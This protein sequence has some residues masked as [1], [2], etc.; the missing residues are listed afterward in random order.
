MLLDVVLRCYDG[1]NVHTYAPRITG[2]QTPKAEV[3]KRC[4]RSLV[5]SLTAVE[6]RLTILDDRCCEETKRFI[7]SIPGVQILEAAP[8]NNASWL[9]AVELCGRSD[10]RY[11][12]QVEDDYLHAPEA[13]PAMLA[14]MDLVRQKKLPNVVIHPYDDHDNYKA[15]HLRPGYVL[16]GADRHWRTNTYSTA[17]CLAEPWIFRQPEW[18]RLAR[19]YETPEGRAQN[20]HEGTTINRI[21]HDG[22][23]RARL[24]TPLPSLAVA[25]NENEPPL[26]DWRHWWEHYA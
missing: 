17:V 7:Q 15:D 14:F 8:G 10:A 9:Q 4:V 6:H 21:W 20:V 2:A 16:H 25:L 12:Y 18:E 26:F 5:A 1:G 13:I 11:C 22:E 24:F 3:L 23:A 19:L